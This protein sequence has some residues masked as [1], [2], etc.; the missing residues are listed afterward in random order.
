M[1]KSILFLTNAYPDFE[2]S[3]RGI[4]IQKMAF[5][6]EEEGYQISVVTPKIYRKS[7]CFEEQNGIKVYRFPFWAGNKLLIEYEKIPYLKMVLYYLSGIML[8]TYVLLRNRCS[9]IHAHWAIPTGLIGAYVGGFLK[10]PFIV[11]I[12]GSDLK[13]AMESAGLVRKLF[14]YVCRKANHV[15]C[16]SEVQKREVEKLRIPEGKISTIP[17]G[18][19][20][21]FIEVGENRKQKGN[22]QTITILSNRNL[23]PN[24][25]VSQLIKAI[26]R[27]LLEEPRAKCFIAG[28][29]EERKNLE[30][31]VK[32][33]KV[34]AAVQFLGQVP[35]QEMRNLLAQSDIYVSTSLSDGT[36]VSLLEA[37][38]AGAFPVVTD[39]PSNREW[40]SDGDNG[41]LFPV[42]DEGRLADRIVEGIRNRELL[43]RAIKRNREIIVEK[44]YWKKN[45]YKTIELYDQ[46]LRAI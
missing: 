39:I 32:R 42:G 41:F 44:G 35:H 14:L 13:M 31:L 2:S 7:H 38:G 40:I 27:I 16:V 28:N 8:T 36:S 9:L 46:A 23:L 29:G 45:I 37:M 6:L 30:E 24:Y 25:N 17:M 5:L 21:T 11:T 26:P 15:N 33:L 12:H 19:D 3:Y 34:S 4:F 20:E 22:K 10:K 18:V 1:R 43:E